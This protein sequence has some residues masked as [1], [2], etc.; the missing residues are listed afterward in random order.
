MIAVEIDEL[1]AGALPDDGRRAGCPSVPTALDGDH[2]RR[3]CGSTTL[4]AAPTAV[5]A[6]LP[7]NVS[8]PVLLH[9]LARFAPGPRAW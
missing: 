4:P 9:L 7:Y 2:R 6:N 1:L 5:V 3:A 8:V